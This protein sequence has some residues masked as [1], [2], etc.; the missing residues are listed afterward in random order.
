MYTIKNSIKNIYRN[1]NSYIKFGILYF[2]IV[3]AAAVFISSFNKMTGIADYISREYASV[4]TVDDMVSYGKY[5]RRTR[6]TKNEL[7]SMK[8]KDGISD[9]RIFKYIYSCSNAKV[10]L[11]IDSEMVSWSV[12]TTYLVGYNQE[13]MN[14]ECDDLILED[15]RM[16]E[17]ENEVVIYKDRQRPK[18]GKTKDWND[19]SL[20]D[21]I[22]V[23]SA[24]ITHEYTVVGILAEEPEKKG[25][26]NLYI[27]YTDFDGA[28]CFD[29]SE[30][31]DFQ[32]IMKSGFQTDN[33]PM[34]GS[35]DCISEGYHALISLEK[36]DDFTSMRE[37]FTDEGLYLRTLLPDANKML[38]LT[39]ST[40]YSIAAYLMISCLILIAIAV[41]ATN[42]LLNSRKYEIAVLRSVGMSKLRLVIG[43]VVENLVFVWGVTTVALMVSAFIEPMFTSGVIGEIRK[44]ISAE[45]LSMMIH[46][47]WNRIINILMVY[48]GT[49]AIVIISLAITVI[50]IVRFEP[51]KIFSKQH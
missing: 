34:F 42:I 25:Y 20:G 51:L 44:M 10:T 6:P 45:T 28:E 33:I 21:K 12:P 9:V 37:A 17:N 41:I 32:M 8:D 2:I 13:S 43:L 16:F 26:N 49:T 46:V 15:G 24:D 27:M 4:V 5:A 11:E 1:R 50:C 40:K 38:R 36:P 29:I 22:I 14:L 7:L 39:N 30:P 31:D 19:L 23:S 35:S 48:S 47:G 18:I 3:L